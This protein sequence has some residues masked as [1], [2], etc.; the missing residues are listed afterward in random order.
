MAANKTLQE[1]DMLLEGIDLQQLC[2]KTEKNPF[3]ALKS[4]CAKLA[5]ESSSSFEQ[6]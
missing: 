2:L 4:L 6:K 3:P 1:L 5:G